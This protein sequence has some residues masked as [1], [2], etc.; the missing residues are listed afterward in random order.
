M[1]V[2]QMHSGTTQKFHLLTN[3]MIYRVIHLAKILHGNEVN[4]AHLCVGRFSIR[5]ENRGANPTVIQIGQD[6]KGCI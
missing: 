2:S 6:Q 3:L 1:F 4:R 5:L